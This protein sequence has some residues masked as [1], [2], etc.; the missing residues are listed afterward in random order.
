MN[1][2]IRKLSEIEEN[3]G[4]MISG[5]KNRSEQLKGQLAEDMRLL[6]EKYR[7]QEA[8]ELERRKQELSAKAEAEVEAVRQQYAAGMERLT[9]Q[10]SG[11]KDRMAQEILERLTAV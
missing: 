9:E 3:A 7:K 10:F 4:T 8:E 1:E 2:I 6:D 11:E 5:A